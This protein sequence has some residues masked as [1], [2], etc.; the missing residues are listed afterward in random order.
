MGGHHPSSK[1]HND[2]PRRQQL[3][4]LRNLFCLDKSTAD[5]GMVVTLSKVKTQF[6]D[7]GRTRPMLYALQNTTFNF[8]SAH[9]LAQS[10]G[11]P[12]T[13][14]LWHQRP[15]QLVE[16]VWS[17]GQL[18]CRFGRFILS[19]TDSTRYC[20]GNHHSKVHSQVIPLRRLYDFVGVDMTHSAIGL[21]KQG[22][23]KVRV[24]R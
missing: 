18:T 12:T 23:P 5:F 11:R 22:W 16:P 9:V 2:S 4:R 3:R 24:E 1:A 10:S 17:L 14:I 15:I 20:T 8:D 7:E 19:A 13:I 21:H 6:D